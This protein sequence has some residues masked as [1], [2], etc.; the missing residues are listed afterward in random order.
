MGQQLKEV[1]PRFS[2]TFSVYD[3]PDGGIHIAWIPNGI[4]DEE[5]QHIDIPG[6]A[7]NLIKKMQAGEM[8]N[9]AEIAKLAM[10]SGIG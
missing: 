4:D 1:K 2:G 8:P 10:Q 7:V 6:F 3:T 9:P 5:T